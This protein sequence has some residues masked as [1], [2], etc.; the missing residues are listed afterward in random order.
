MDLI[1]RLSGK[2]YRATCSKFSQ[3]SRKENP[4]YD[5]GKNISKSWYGLLKAVFLWPDNFA[6]WFKPGLHQ[7]E[8]IVKVWRPDLIYASALPFTSLRIANVLSRK[9]GV[10]WVAEFRDLW[11]D[12]HYNYAPFWRRGIDR[13]F[14]R[15]VIRSCSFLVTV[16]EPLATTLSKRHKKETL[17]ILNGY[18][19]PTNK[20]IQSKD[21]S[22]PLEIVYTGMIYPGRRDPSLLF[23]A[24]SKLNWSERDVIVNFYGRT[25]PGLQKLIDSYGLRNIANVHSSVAHKQA[26]NIQRD[27]DILLLLLWNTK[28]EEG[29]FTGKLFEYIGARRQIICLGMRDGAAASLIKNRELGVVVKSSPELQQQLI[30]WLKEKRTKGFVAP[31]SKKSIEGLSRIEQFS[32]LSKKL[33]SFE[34]ENSLNRKIIIILPGTNRGGTERHVL[35][36]A[37]RLK[38]SFDVSIVT[39]EPLGSLHKDF[40]MAGLTIS[41]L[42]PGRYS[43]LWSFIRLVILFRTEKEALFHF[44]LPKAYIIGG[45]AWFLFGSKKS[46]MF[47]SRRSLNVYQNRHF[48]ARFI[49]RF[50]HTKMD[51]IF[52]NCKKI[53]EELRIEGATDS[54]LKLI[55]NGVNLEPVN[56]TSSEGKGSLLI[57]TQHNGLTLLCL[58]NLIPYKGH[59]DLIHGLSMISNKLPNGWKMLFAGRDDGLKT[60]LFALCRSLD[61]LDKIDFLGE[62]VNTTELVRTVDIVVSASHQEGLSNSVLEAMSQGVALVATNVG[63]NPELVVDGVN[64]LLVEPQ[65]PRQLSEAILTLALNPNL[66]RQFGNASTQIVKNTFS[67]DNCLD[68]Y[69]DFYAKQFHLGK[70]R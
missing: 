11:V 16:S 56:K 59:E 36:V 26:L 17:V 40:E 6:G 27:A 67:M 37:S 55:Y 24:I 8:A 48:F 57:K 51:L 21:N 52:G 47:M 33:T 65:N 41:T 42:N 53:V 68:N 70:L 69:S 29:V 43:N 31:I 10:P 19:L 34:Q 61:L 45:I 13:F 9:I 15:Q 54:K 1:Y 28:A 35:E 18:E 22:A 2:V 49:E 25:L 3:N 12:N 46:H 63:G 5:R 23:E 14:E 32:E 62:V 58:A 20:R 4:K 39:L 30:K 38:N 64:G 60:N 44:F 7:A 66:R 50:L